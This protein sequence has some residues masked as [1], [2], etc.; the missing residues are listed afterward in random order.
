MKLTKNPLTLLNRDDRTVDSFRRLQGDFTIQ[1][2]HI[3]LFGQF[4]F[5]DC[6]NDNE[7]ESVLMAIERMDFTLFL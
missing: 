4:Y 6:P 1:W 2:K 5:G 7:V 3:D